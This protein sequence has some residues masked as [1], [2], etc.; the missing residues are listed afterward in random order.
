M[1]WRLLRLRVKI[2]AN[3]RL[4][5]NIFP[6]ISPDFFFGRL[7]IFVTS[8]LRFVNFYAKFLAVLLLT[9]NPIDTLCEEGINRPMEVFSAKQRMVFEVPWV[10]TGYDISQYDFLNWHGDLEW[11][12]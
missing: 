1:R 9:V 3:L 2:L 10:W 4:T 7:T 5:E 6:L 12:Q 11:E 8:G